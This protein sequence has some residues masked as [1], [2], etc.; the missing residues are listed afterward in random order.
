MAKATTS[1]YRFRGIFLL[2]KD[3]KILSTQAWGITKAVTPHIWTRTAC[4][5]HATVVTWIW[6]VIF[7]LDKDVVTVRLWIVM[8][9]VWPLWIVS[10]IFP[11][12]SRRLHWLVTLGLGLIILSPTFSTLYSFAAWRIGGFAP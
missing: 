7:M 1:R 2:P 11:G 12:K 6:Y 3:K 10:I 5:I 9:I 8:V 4:V